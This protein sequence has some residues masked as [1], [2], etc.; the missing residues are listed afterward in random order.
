MVIIDLLT[1]FLSNLI[2]WISLK[3]VGPQIVAAQTCQKAADHTGKVNEIIN[4]HETKLLFPKTDPQE[5][6]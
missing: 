2:V 6:S 1:L 3:K 5:I 4:V